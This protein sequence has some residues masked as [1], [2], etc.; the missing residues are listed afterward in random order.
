M[1]QLAQLRGNPGTSYLTAKTLSG[2]PAETSY[3][4]RRVDNSLMVEGIVPLV[5][6]ISWPELI[7]AIVTVFE[8]VGAL[9]IFYGSA[10]AVVEIVASAVHRRPPSYS[11]IRREYT[12][13]I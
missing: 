9:I 2:L 13:K 8:A 11:A 12:K 1:A 3:R 5:N 7:N 4:Y 10:R 6:D